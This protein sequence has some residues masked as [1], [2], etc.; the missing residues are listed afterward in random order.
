MYIA[1]VGEGLPGLYI[2][3]TPHHLLFKNQ[4]ESVKLS[5]PQERL[6]IL[7]FINSLSGT[8]AFTLTHSLSSCFPARCS[9]RA[10]PKRASNAVCHSLKAD[11]Q[12]RAC[13]HFSSSNAAA[14]YMPLKLRGAR[15]PDAACVVSSGS[16]TPRAEVPG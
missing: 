13:A 16:A 10:T 12:L 6:I 2:L 1:C 5:G 14:G 4:K 8:C 11:S 7:P 3:P 9:I 15:R